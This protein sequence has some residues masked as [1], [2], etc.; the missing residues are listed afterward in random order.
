[1]KPYKAII[2]CYANVYVNSTVISAPSMICRCL[3]VHCGWYLSRHLHH[4]GY[5]QQ[6]MSSLYL[7]IQRSQE[8]QPRVQEHYLCL[9][10]SKCY[11]HSLT[12]TVFDGRW[13]KFCVWMLA[14]AIWKLCDETVGYE[15]HTTPST[16][17]CMTLQRIAVIW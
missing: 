3:Q 10:H 16:F 14:A 9:L 4:F 17:P 15:P 11:T 7:H 8:H 1:M 6:S 2:L 5:M 12:Y 13:N